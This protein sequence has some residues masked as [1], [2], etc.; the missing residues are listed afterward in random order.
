[1]RQLTSSEKSLLEEIGSAMRTHGPSTVTP[2]VI[3][4]ATRLIRVMTD[5]RPEL[6]ELVGPVCTTADVTSWL[7][8]SRQSIN[9]AIRDH[10]ILAVQSPSRTWYYPTW[11]LADGHSIIG[12]LRD[13]LG[14]LSE[15]AEGVLAAQ[16]FWTPADA[17]DQLTPA[18]WL[19]DGNDVRKA[20]KAAESA[21][22]S[23][24]RRGVKAPEFK[25]EV[26]TTT[27][28]A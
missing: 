20:V 19:R 13:V 15:R 11:Q 9:K 12:G 7:G 27:P 22:T 18:Q 25:L 21:A 16:W 28:G 23:M 1:M 14:R 10:R 2:D 8:T 24:V 3:D 17:L 4:E 26:A 6:T 5:P